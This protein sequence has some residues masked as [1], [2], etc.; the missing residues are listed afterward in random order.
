MKL[1]W[2]PQAL[3]LFGSKSLVQAH[4][5]YSANGLAHQEMKGAILNRQT[6]DRQE[7]IIVML[8]SAHSSPLNT[9]LMNVGQLKVCLE[10]L[11]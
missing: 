1:M 5:H 2:F 4:S 10:K 11:S 3:L 9:K 8:I 6:K 7:D